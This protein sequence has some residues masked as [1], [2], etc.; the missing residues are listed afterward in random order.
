MKSL[1]FDP[2]Q[3]DLLK[4]ELRSNLRVVCGFESSTLRILVIDNPRV[5]S[6]VRN[7]I[8]HEQ[9]ILNEYHEY[10]D[11][12]LIILEY[13]NHIV[14]LNDLYGCFPLFEYKH[15]QDHFV[16]TTYNGSYQ[17]ELDEIAVYDYF[18]FNH[19]ILD[20]TLNKHIRRVKGGSKITIE[21]TQLHVEQLFD[22]NDWLRFIQNART[23]KHTSTD[24]VLT[25]DQSVQSKKP[26]LTLTGGFDS[27]LLLAALLNGNK[28]FDTVTWGEANN[29]QSAV[30]KALSDQFGITH[31]DMILDE[32]FV[33]SIPEKKDYILQNLPETPFLID[34]PQ[35]IHMC[36]NLSKGTE[37]ICGFMGSEI[38]RGP[39]YSSQVTLTA[40]AGKLGLCKTKAEIEALILRY[41]ERYK[42]FTETNLQENIS[43]LV[44]RYSTYS[45]ATLDGQ[46]ENSHI[47]KF[48]FYEKYGKMYSEFIKIH[49]DHDIQLIN[50]YMDLRYIA[51][52]FQQNRTLT[53]LTP[54]ENNFYKNFKLYTYYAKEIR[55]IA[56]Q[57]M[58]TRVDRGYRL[59][60]LV[61]IQ[62]KLSLIPMQM[63]RMIKKRQKTKVVKT[64]DSFAW[65]KSILSGINQHTECLKPI[66]NI[67]HAEFEERLSK[68]STI[69]DFEKL[70][71]LLYLGL[72]MSLE[73]NHYA[74]NTTH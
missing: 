45:K 3:F 59:Q 41:N 14:V 10:L 46:P 17:F 20:A 36:E 8:L 68:I 7:G 1:P 15:G 43:Q 66:T 53:D 38:I 71:I 23:S 32:K 64:V 56:P 42:L 29:T 37:L 13:Q 40:F 55:H 52:V 33:Q 25:I 6:L 4:H 62:G 54:Y 67:R 34:V 35:F 16:S 31:H 49:F 12:G 69:S 50:P 60:D 21:A 57:L 11:Y 65:Y 74:A 18:F 30:A 58:Q 24:L 5:T 28:T 26:T 9:N 63:R 22:W 39:S 72:G 47:F 51:G 44:E 48:L 19:F 2:R 27:R 61:S 73:T 70:Q